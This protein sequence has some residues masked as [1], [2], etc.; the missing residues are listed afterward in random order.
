MK[1]Y[2]DDV[3]EISD[4]D[5]AIFIRF[6]EQNKGKFSKRDIEK[7]C[8]VVTEAEVNLSRWLIKFIYPSEFT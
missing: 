8:T 7:E 4:K 5:V 1:R 6:L 2:L 3:F